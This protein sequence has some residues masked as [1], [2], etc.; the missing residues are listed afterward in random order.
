MHIQVNNK[1]IYKEDLDLEVEG[2][3]IL[4][5]TVGIQV[6]TIFRVIRGDT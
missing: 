2:D 5:V 6:G 1:T 3:M 4:W